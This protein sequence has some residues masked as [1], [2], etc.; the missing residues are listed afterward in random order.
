MV[1]ITKG[2]SFVCSEQRRGSERYQ[3]S[4]VSHSCRRSK[5]YV[6]DCS[7]AV[8]KVRG[9]YCTIFPRESHVMYNINIEDL[10]C[11]PIDVAACPG[12]TVLNVRLGL[13]AWTAGHYMQIGRPAMNSVRRI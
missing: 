10:S 2:S 11:D 4:Y 1:N 13:W 9:A 12:R 8:Q 3:L 5:S 6:D 7:T